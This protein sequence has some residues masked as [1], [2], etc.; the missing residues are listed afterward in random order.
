MRRTI[1]LLGCI[2]AFCGISQD[3]RFSTREAYGITTTADSPGELL[4]TI[5]IPDRAEKLLLN[6]MA[7]A[8]VDAEVNDYRAIGDVLRGPSASVAIPDSAR[9]LSRSAKLITKVD[10]D[11]FALWAVLRNP[12][13]PDIPYRKLLEKTAGRVRA[14]AIRKHR[15]FASYL[16]VSLTGREGKVFEASEAY[17]ANRHFKQTGSKSRVLVTAV[18][19]D[20]AHAADLVMR[21]NGRITKRFQFKAGGR[22][23]WDALRKTKYDGMTI[24]THPEELNWLK[25]ELRKRKLANRPIT[26]RYARLDEALQSGKLTDEVVPGLKTL[27]RKST[28]TKTINM[29]RRQWE[30]M[31]ATMD[32]VA[33]SGV[34]KPLVKSSFLT[35]KYGTKIGARII[36]VG[37]KL[38]VGADFAFAGYGYYDTIGRYRAGQLD[39]DLTA[40][41][42]A[43]HTGEVGV[44][45]VGVFLLLTP[46]PTGATKIAGI[47]V[48]VVSVALGGADISLDVIAAGRTKARQELLKRI[49]RKQRHEVV[50]EKLARE[51]AMIQVVSIR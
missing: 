47:V 38:A 48:I 5:A 7:S 1:L 15:T 4:A 6:P 8:V 14:K 33:R 19:G 2:F 35:A 44:G 25:A 16:D 46:E 3:S 21:K 26:G 13:T 41:K 42:L 45:A 28:N 11:Q 30:S 27:S 18:E 37:T 12:K 22:A 10:G 9:A 39:H 23:A 32:S 51:A 29:M 50:L 34:V 49:D 24:V 31:V 17:R 36:N 43:V 40:A 20:P